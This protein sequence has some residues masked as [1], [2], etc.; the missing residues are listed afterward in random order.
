M[1]EIVVDVCVIIRCG[2]DVTVMSCQSGVSPA[3]CPTV[4]MTAHCQVSSYPHCD[5]IA[6]WSKQI[7]KGL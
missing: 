2:G 4:T 3:P 6:D 7:D 1:I 5:M